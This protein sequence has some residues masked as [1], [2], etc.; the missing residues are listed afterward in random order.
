VDDDRWYDQEAH[1]EAALEANGL[2][3]DY[4]NV[5]GAG[6]PYDS[7]PLE[8][9]KRYPILVWFTGY[10]WYQ[11]L[12]P[13]EEARLATY[14]EGGGRLFLS[15]QDYLYDSGFTSFATDYLGVLA[16]SEDLTTTV[17]T[18]VAGNLIGDGLGPYDLNYPFD[19][20]SDALTPTI[21]TETA[22]R[23]GHGAPTGLAH[24][25]PSYRT[26][27]FSYPFEALDSGAA[28][29]VMERVVGWL[30]W[31]G[32]STLAAD[33]TVVAEGDP[34]T[35][36]ITLRNDGWDG[37][38]Q[39]S[40]FNPIAANTSYVAGSLQ[41]AEAI[42]HPSTNTVTWNGGIASGQSVIVSYRV[43]V[44]SPLAPGTVI[45]N[46]AYISYD[47]H[48]VLFD[49]EVDIRV[50][51]P[52]L[53]AST[54]TVDK[55]TAEHGESLAYTIVLRN[56]GIIDASSAVLTNVIPAHVAYVPGSLSAEGAP[57]AVY[58]EGKITWSGPVGL[59]S[60]V[61]ITYG[62]VVSTTRGDLTIRNVARLEDDSGYVTERTATTVVPPLTQFF[63]LIMK[64]YR[65]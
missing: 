46:V 34:L 27:F 53:S 31:L 28:E 40:L 35:Y 1:Y 62:V 57:P 47:D 42:Y 60:P 56:Q 52:D 17:A 29:K 7:P 49:R 37:I 2:P 24:A 5:N 21:S 38:S 63:P 61:T 9:L 10:D 58:G 22:F 36:T 25:V 32:T 39:A 51:A 64:N 54:I 44:A 30:S 4:W 48:Y 3:Y 19:N 12:T 13:E 55:E 65:R 18:G 20:W 45:S 43:G 14:L 11:T 15:G 59:G 41:P 6:W 26:V 33:R 8:I 16:Y 50:N 23:G